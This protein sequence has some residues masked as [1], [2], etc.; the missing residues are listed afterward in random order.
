M[1]AFRTFPDAEAVA[2][3]GIRSAS[4]TLGSRVYSSVP[5]NLPTY[6][7]AVVQR[8]GGVPAHRR[9]LDMAVIQVDVWGSSKSMARTAAE[10]AR[11]ALMG[12]EGTAVSDPDA[13]V[14]GVEDATG[15]FWFPDT[16]TSRDR[17]TFSV[18]MYLPGSVT[19]PWVLSDAVSGL[20][21]WYDFSDASTLFSDTARTTPAVADG[22]IGGVT[23][24]SGTARHLSQATGNNQPLFKVG[25]VNSRNAALF[26]DN[27][28]TL[29]SATLSPD[30][31]QPVTHILV[32]KF[33]AATGA[34]HVFESGGVTGRHIIRGTSDSG[35]KWGVF[36]TN[37]VNTSTVVDTNTHVIVWKANNT[38]NGMFFLD[39][40]SLNFNGAPGTNALERIGFGGTN[41]SGDDF[42]VCEY[43]LL[44][45]NISD[46]AR[47]AAETGLGDKWGVTVT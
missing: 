41:A 9:A 43:G 30:I 1:A 47:N 31:D 39:G 17:Y 42:Y 23:D 3:K 33:V 44:E 40:T 37:S 29:L 18:N 13:V 22:G 36:A 16:D 21:A 15:L 24:L 32:V 4:T 2:G 10:E 12:L 14:S 27:T 34:A 45:G 19:D 20:A 28:D 25:A 11:R 26:Q 7:F 38:Q 35:I 6:P 5:K 46:D 8:L